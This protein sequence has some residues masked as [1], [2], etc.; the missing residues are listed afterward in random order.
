[1]YEYFISSFMLVMDVLCCV[2]LEYGEVLGV[3]GI[4]ILA[5]LGICCC[6]DISD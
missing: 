2:N 3:L 1:V 4:L 6:E 5:E